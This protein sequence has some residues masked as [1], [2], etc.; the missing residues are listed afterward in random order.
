MLSITLI[1]EGNFDPHFLAQ[2][3]VLHQH[4][5]FFCIFAALWQTRTLSIMSKYAVARERAEPARITI[6]E[7]R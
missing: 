6:S 7:I 3:Y 4:K 2:T 1:G 5:H